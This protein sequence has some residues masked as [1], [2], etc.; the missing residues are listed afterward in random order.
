MRVFQ[1]FAAF[2]SEIN[3]SVIN[4]CFGWMAH[5]WL[6]RLAF[7]SCIM[8]SPRCGGS[9]SLEL[10]DHNLGGPFGGSCDDSL[11]S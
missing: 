11:I 8:L 4:D 9:R 6:N 7:I 5:F 1:G 2:I 3:L 10:S